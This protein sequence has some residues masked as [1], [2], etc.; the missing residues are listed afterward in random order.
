MEIVLQITMANV[1]HD[2]IQIIALIMVLDE[3]DNIWVS[4]PLHNLHFIVDLF[5]KLA[6]LHETAS[7]EL[8][9][10]QELT[11]HL[12]SKLVD[13]CECAFADDTCEESAHDK[14]K[15]V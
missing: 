15:A 14:K 2:D 4:E 1:L 7:L 6:I 8:F 10:S 3:L 11:L 5:V 9:C 13:S 12:S